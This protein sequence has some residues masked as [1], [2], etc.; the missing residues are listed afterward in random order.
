MVWEGKHSLWELITALLHWPGNVMGCRALRLT[1]KGCSTR[2][3]KSWKKRDAGAKAIML[4]PDFPKGLGS[5][6][7]IQAAIYQYFQG[8]EDFL[9]MRVTFDIFI[10]LFF[11]LSPIYHNAVRLSFP[12]SAEKVTRLC[13]SCL[14]LVPSLAAPFLQEAQS[15]HLCFYAAQGGGSQPCSPAGEVLSVSNELILD[16][17]EIH[18]EQ[19][20]FFAVYHKLVYKVN[21]KRPVI[22]A[23]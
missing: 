14:L 6:R 12:T 10:L 22:W 23:I 8:P 13:W 19:K 9:S 17:N 3:R 2:E 1:A 15:P 4:K 20:I 7:F 11:F 5:Q 18:K 21:R 16:N